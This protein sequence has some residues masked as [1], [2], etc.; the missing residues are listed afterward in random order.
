MPNQHS[1]VPTIPLH[2]QIMNHSAFI[3]GSVDTTFI[4]RTWQQKK[5]A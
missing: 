4:E 3:E 2:R 1:Q 5:P